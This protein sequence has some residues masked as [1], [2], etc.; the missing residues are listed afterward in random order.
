MTDLDALIA[1]MRKQERAATAEK[2]EFTTW[3]ES[4]IHKML[5]GEGE[6]DRLLR[7]E[8]TTLTPGER[9]EVERLANLA[10]EAAPNT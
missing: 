10:A 2:A 5:A 4:D 9:A 7:G 1:L 3:S 8:H 6:A